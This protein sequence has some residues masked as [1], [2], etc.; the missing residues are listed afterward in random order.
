MT[1]RVRRFYAGQGDCRCF[2]F[3]SGMGLLPLSFDRGRAPVS[4]PVPVDT[5]WGCPCPFQIPPMLPLILNG[6]GAI[7]PKSNKICFMRDLFVLKIHWIWG[8]SVHFSCENTNFFYFK[9]FFMAFSTHRQGMIFGL[10]L[11]L[12]WV[13]LVVIKS[14]IG[15]Y[16][17]IVLAVQKI[18]LGFFIVLKFPTSCPIRSRSW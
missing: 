15:G 5:R 6:P 17:E 13:I 18:L 2:P 11:V 14:C 12:F 10:F 7:S 4:G 9:R 3:G 8:Q 1:Y 16:F